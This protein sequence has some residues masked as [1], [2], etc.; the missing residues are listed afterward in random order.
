MGG[1]HPGTLTSISSLVGHAQ[2]G[3]WGAADEDR[4]L[5]RGYS[6][7]I[8]RISPHAPQEKFWGRFDSAPRPPYDQRKGRGPSVGNLP[9]VTGDSGRRARALRCALTG[10]VRTGDGGW[11]LWCL[12]SFRTLRL[13][14]GEVWGGL[15]VLAPTLGSRG[16]AG[17]RAA[18][19]GV[20]PPPTKFRAEIWGVGQVVAPYG[21]DTGS[22][23]RRAMRKVRE[24][25]S[26]I[27]ASG[28]Q[29]SVCASGWEETGNCGRDHPQSTQQRRTIPQPPSGRQLPLHKG[30]FGAGGCGFPRRP[31]GPPRNDNVFLSFRGAERRGDPSFFT[32][33]DGR[34]F[35][36]PRSS[37]PTEGQPKSQQWADVLKAW[38][39][40][41]KF[42]AEI[43]GV[44]HRYRPLRNETEAAATAGAAL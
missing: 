28:A 17:V 2:R 21:S 44:S 35:G 4:R 38:L 5:A 10:D 39:S 18:V 29:R 34:G 30:A 8:K 40:P 27:Q 13:A 41:T 22:A 3:A 42:R 9:G 37:A 23:K 15:V 20:W 19:P 43:W 16:P 26:T 24:A 32:M 7:P 14:G 1:W 6:F 12:R 36:P 11:K 31:I 33:D 25:P